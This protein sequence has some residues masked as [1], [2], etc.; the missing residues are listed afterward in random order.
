MTD[1]LLFKNDSHPLPPGGSGDLSSVW[2]EAERLAWGT[3][4]TAEEILKV[5]RRKRE[6][7]Y[8]KAMVRILQKHFPPDGECDSERS[9]GS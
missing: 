3:D 9:N 1:K 7:E 5:V 2:S 6:R 4:M 8:F